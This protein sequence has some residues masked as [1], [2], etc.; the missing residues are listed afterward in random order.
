MVGIG[1][2]YKKGQY[3]TLSLKLKIFFHLG[4]KLEPICTNISPSEKE[5]RSIFG[6]TPLLKVNKLGSLTVLLKEYENE[7]SCIG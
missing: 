3:R 1:S 5:N 4:A 2:G 6:I 7:K